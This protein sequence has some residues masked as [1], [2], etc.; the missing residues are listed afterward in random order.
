MMLGI[1]LSGRHLLAVLTFVVASVDAAGIPEA[2]LARRM[3]A[4]LPASRF[5]CSAA[6]TRL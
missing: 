2:G 3:T 1:E 4:R 6:L 5:S